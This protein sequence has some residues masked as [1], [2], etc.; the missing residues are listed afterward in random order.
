MK[1]RRSSSNKVKPQG[2]PPQKTLLCGMQTPPICPSNYL[3][4]QS[5]SCASFYTD[6]PRCWRRRLWSKSP[7]PAMPCGLMSGCQSLLVP[8]S[9]CVPW[10]LSNNTEDHC[11]VQSWGWGDSH[12]CRQDTSDWL[13]LCLR[14]IHQ[15]SELGRTGLNGTQTHNDFPT[16]HPESDMWQLNSPRPPQFQHK[17]LGRKE[18]S[19]VATDL[20]G[21]TVSCN[22][23]P[24]SVSTKIPTIVN[25]STNKGESVK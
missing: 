2:S 11:N 14:L 22:K 16:H 8:S 19:A 9:F 20:S 12:P 5:A 10:S 3:S 6:A 24:S 23:H 21:K 13:L 17:A 18:R 7:S 1:Q 15:A 4:S 25:K